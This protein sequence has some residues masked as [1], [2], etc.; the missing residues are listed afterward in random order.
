LKPNH[1]NIDFPLSIILF[2]NEPKR[3]N[4]YIYVCNNP[5][6]YFDPT[7]K[8][9]RIAIAAVAGYLLGRLAV[10]ACECYTAIQTLGAFAK[11]LRDIS[12]E[13]EDPLMPRRRMKIIIESDQMKDALKYCGKFIVDLYTG[14]A[15]PWAA[16]DIP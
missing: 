10:Q 11:N 15:D 1:N 12:C 6:N 4:A 13:S 3:W 5:L 2:K 14:V 8:F 16:S 7:G 9:W